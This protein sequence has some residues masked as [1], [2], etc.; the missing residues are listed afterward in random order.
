[1]KPL[2]GLYKDENGDDYKADPVNKSCKQAYALIA[3]GC[4]IVGRPLHDQKG[5]EA[6]P[7]GKGIG[8]YMPG[9]AQEGKAVAQ[10]TAEDLSDENYKCYYQA[11][12]KS[13]LRFIVHVLLSHFSFS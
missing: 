10:E 11:Q 7:E 12:K 3:I 8:Q 2:V 9:I 5:Y 6:Q 13:F 4:L 1:M